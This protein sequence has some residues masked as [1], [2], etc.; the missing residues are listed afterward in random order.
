MPQ[1]QNRN[2]EY[3]KSKSIKREWT[4][5][6]KGLNTL[7]RETELGNDEY[8][9]GDNIILEG[10]GVPTGRWGTQKYF[11]AN[12]TGS[13]RGFVFFNE[14]QTDGSYDRE[15]LAL[16]DEGY[17]A[18]KNGASSTR[19]NGQSWPSGSIVRS[20]QLGGEA[21]LVSR[22]VVFTKYNGTILQAFATISAPTNLRAT[23]ISGVTGTNRISYKVASVGAVGGSSESSTNYVL[24][25]VP[26][27]LTT[28]RINLSWNAI[29]AATFSGYEIYRGTE[30]DEAYLASVGPSVTSYADI[31]EPVSKITLA[32]SI[33]TTGGVKS[34][35]IIKYKDRI[36]LID[37]DDP[38]KLL[39]SGRYPYH[40]SFST[41]YGGGGV[42]I[43]PDGG[44]SITG[45]AVQPISDKIVAYKDHSSYLV[46]L[47]LVTVGNEFLLDPTY[48][49]IS[50]SVGCSNQDTIVP[51]ENDV[52]YFGRDGIYVTGYEPNFLNIIRTNE[53]S[54]RIR[55]YLDTISDDDYKNAC[56]AYFENRYI[57]SL[58]GKREMIV[59]DRERG[60]FAGIWKLPFGISHMRKYYDESGTEKWVL[61]SAENNQTYTF[62]KSVNSDDGTVILKKFR[63]NKEDFGDWTLLSIL[64]F[65]YILFGN[66][67]G[68]TNVNI[69]VEDRV[70][71][72]RNAK[73][74]TITGAEVAGISGYGYNPYGL[75]PYGETVAAYS[76][77]TN[78]IT[79]WGTL[80]KQ[81]RLVQ[82]EVTSNANNSNFKLLS[83]KMTAN[84][85]AEG[86]LYSG[87][88]V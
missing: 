81:A 45:L 50:T 68:E 52:F 47:D 23:N 10:A 21:Y 57:V 9:V 72:T 62:E 48:Q 74:F 32:P 16:T 13:I 28:T 33:N 65:F 71:N 59:Y 31:G 39:V 84:K 2:T 14:R 49:P 88:R 17:L 56:A 69:I 44:E 5:F 70:G 82:V 27:D 54:A 29:S 55:P 64:R 41:L 73:T 11:L 87:Q 34:P 36:L 66:I 77:S 24:N 40:T 79:R 1:Y 30:G 83:I 35:V 3:R 25:G 26:F 22:D 67:T 37:K 12:N 86:S 75:Y 61:G 42:Y 19:I 6:R 63:T 85:Q 58:P 80:F 15:I 53:I 38:T 4:N 20:E 43:D 46:N 76:A 18:R 8:A 7:L 60:C 51:V 78:E